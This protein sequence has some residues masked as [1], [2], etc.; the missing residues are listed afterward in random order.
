MSIPEEYIINDIRTNKDFN[1]KSFS[2]YLLSDVFKV[3]QINYMT[4]LYYI[5]VNILT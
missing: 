3:K 5:I 1:I 4:D 2:G